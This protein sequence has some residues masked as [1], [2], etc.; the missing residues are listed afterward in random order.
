MKE[1]LIKQPPYTFIR[2][3]HNTLKSSLKYQQIGGYDFFLIF[4]LNFPKIIVSNMQIALNYSWNFFLKKLKIQLMQNTVAV[5][6]YY[7]QSSIS[8][9]SF[10]AYFSL[11]I[12]QSIALYHFRLYYLE[13]EVLSVST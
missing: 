11:I 5:Q 8:F 3:I 12:V 6:Y 1:N 10:S 2:F 7:Q 13:D 4:I 9:R